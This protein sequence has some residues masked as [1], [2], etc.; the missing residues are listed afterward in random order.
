MGWHIRALNVYKRDRWQKWIILALLLTQFAL[1][2]MLISQKEE[3]K[4]VIVRVNKLGVPI[5]VEEATGGTLPA[6]TKEE[7][8]ATLLQIL[9]DWRQRTL[10]K[11]H[12]Q[13]KYTRIFNH[14]LRGA[15]PDKFEE[16]IV[17]GN[18]H[19]FVNAKEKKDY[20]PI[21]T[22]GSFTSKIEITSVTESSDN[23]YNFR[24]WETVYD[25]AGK[26]K[27]RYPLLITFTVEQRAPTD[28]GL[29]RR[30]P[31]GIYIIDIFGAIEKDK[32]EGK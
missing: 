25:A 29:V 11:T 14:Y 23:T 8:K 16:I 26:V 9:E 30:N 32:L 21:T 2:Y 22:V 7:I 1:T 5:N 18:F 24:F 4:V 20:D 13:R 31:Y 19:P 28:T 12:E 6:I 10:D 27:A 3:V 15:A 17:S